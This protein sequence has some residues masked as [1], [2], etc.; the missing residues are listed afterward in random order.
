MDCPGHTFTSHHCAHCYCSSDLS[1]SDI[2]I[3]PH[4]MLKKIITSINMAIVTLLLIPFYFLI[5]G[6]A[7]MIHK[8]VAKKNRSDG[9]FW[10]SFQITN[11]FTSPY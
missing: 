5:I 9:T 7:Y 4:L 8:L 2:F 1:S 10:K 6:I 3:P 11:D